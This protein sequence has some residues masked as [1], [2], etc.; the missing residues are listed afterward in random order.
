MAVRM[1]TVLDVVA[2]PAEILTDFLSCL[3]VFNNMLEVRSS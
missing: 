1:L 3:D 2:Q